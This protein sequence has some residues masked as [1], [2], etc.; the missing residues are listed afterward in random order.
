MK[1]TLRLENS[2]WSATFVSDAEAIL[3]AAKMVKKQ[4][5][6]TVCDMAGKVLSTTMICPA[7]FDPA[8]DHSWAAPM[9]AARK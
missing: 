9:E 2:D 7:R 6:L 1:Y 4:T 8:H 5:E 3:H